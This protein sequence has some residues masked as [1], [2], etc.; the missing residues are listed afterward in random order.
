M[1][2]KA[3]HCENVCCKNCDVG[4]K[5]CKKC[6]SIGENGLCTTF[7][8]GVI[9]YFNLVW[10]SL[11]S[12]N[13]IDAVELTDDLRIGVNFVMRTYR[14]SLTVRDWGTCRMFLLTNGENGGGL[15]YEEIIELEMDH[16]VFQQICEDVA[17]GNLPK[18]RRG[19]PAK[20]SQPFGWLSPTGNFQKADFAEHENTAQKIISKRGFTEEFNAWDGRR[21]ARDF[22][23][24]VKGYCL[25]H[26]PFGDGGYIISR[27]KPFT[28]EQREFLYGY[29]MDMGD[30]LRAESFL[31]EE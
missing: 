26:N 9:Y 11:S 14:L 4:Q 27:E 10:H 2:K 16:E 30:K 6:P 25:I 13:F 12:K 28:K 29:F 18:L 5:T 24:Q 22:L 20:D 15:K 1:A 8:K 3:I 31:R 7:E 21:T 19:K 23:T 17:V